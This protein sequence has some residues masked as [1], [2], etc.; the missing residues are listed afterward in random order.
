MTF[1]CSSGS[2]FFLRGHLWIVVIELPRSPK[3]V[4]IVNLTSRKPNSDTTVVL[5]SDTHRFVKHETVVNY[6]DA[7]I[8]S[9]KT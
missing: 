8:V 9:K 7:K 4:V 2:S 6:F 3:E 1:D 5:Q